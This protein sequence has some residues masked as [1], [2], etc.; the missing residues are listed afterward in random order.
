MK[1]VSFLNYFGFGRTDELAG[2]DK[3]A[4]RALPGQWYISQELYELERRAIFSRRWLMVTHRSRFHQPG[5]W[6]QY[7]IAGFGFI[8]TRDGSGSITAFHN[9]CKHCACPL[10]EG[11]NATIGVSTCKCYAWS[12]KLAGKL[13]KAARDRELTTSDL[14]NLGLFL[15]HVHVD[16]NGF[17]WVNLDANQKPDIAWTDEFDTVDRQARY[18]GFNFDDYEYDHT[19]EMQTTYNWKLAADNYNECYH[20]KTTHPDLPAVANL[21]AYSVDVRDGY[22]LHNVATT[23][24]QAAAG[25]RVCPTWYLPAASM[26]V[27]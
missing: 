11:E 10:V 3:K 23:P 9:I 14:K 5:D 12:D 2:E 18:E 19:W 7:C 21:E 8:I 27:M 13:A 26:N 1:P 25:L 17:I 4:V 15:I 6:L 16:F 20:C 24:E 22:I